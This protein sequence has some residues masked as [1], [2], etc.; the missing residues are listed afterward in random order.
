MTIE[1]NQGPWLSLLLLT[2][3]NS[4][5]TSLPSTKGQNS[6]VDRDKTVNVLTYVIIFF[7]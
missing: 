6:R 4:N 1:S 2:F 3:G 7:Y 5:V